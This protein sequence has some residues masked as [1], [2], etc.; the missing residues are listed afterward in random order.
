MK[1][2]WKK[3]DQYNSILIIGH[4]LTKQSNPH[5]IN[6][7]NLNK[8]KLTI[9]SHFPILSSHTFIQLTIECPS[10]YDTNAS[11]LNTL[12]LYHIVPMPGISICYVFEE[13]KEIQIK[14]H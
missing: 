14:H 2:L 8:C 9:H 3:L 4:F 6:K 11:P 7:I 1:S 10:E 13:T 5:K 12:P